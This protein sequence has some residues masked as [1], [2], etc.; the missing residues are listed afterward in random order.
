MKYCLTSWSGTS[1]ERLPLSTEQNI[2]A[3]LWHLPL[4]RTSE[5][6]HLS[7]ATKIYVTAWCCSTEVRQYCLPI[8]YLCYFQGGWSTQ[9]EMC[10]SYAF[11]YPKIT[12]N[13]CV[14]ITAYPS[15]DYSEVMHSSA[16]FQS[17]TLSVPFFCSYDKVYHKQEVRFL[18]V[19]G[20]IVTR[21]S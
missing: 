2:S 18:F 19:L 3:A 5:E 8:T 9:E 14:S 12:M 15:L 1:N 10:N 20:Q 16:K 13:E 6:Q 11:Y 4:K 17:S 7:R 21:K